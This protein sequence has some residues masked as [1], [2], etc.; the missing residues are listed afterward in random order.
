MSKIKIPDN[1]IDVPINEIYGELLS[2]FN[3]SDDSNVE[4]R[5]N[6]L[7]V[8]RISHF[9]DSYHELKTDDGILVGFD[10]GEWGGGLFFFSNEDEIPLDKSKPLEHI[11]MPFYDMNEELIMEGNIKSIFN[12]NDKIYFLEGLAHLSSDR[13]FYMN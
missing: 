7:I 11:F 13:G 8:K 10:F 3:H 4:I 1:F 5:D 2:L 9:S 12:Y 6:K